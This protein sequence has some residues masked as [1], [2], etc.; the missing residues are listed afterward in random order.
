MH[1]NESWSKSIKNM[2]IHVFNI[3]HLRSTF[4]RFATSFEEEEHNGFPE[5]WDILWNVH[6]NH[7]HLASVLSHAAS[8]WPFETRNRATLI[9][10]VAR[11]SPRSVANPSVLLRLT[12]S[13]LQ[14]WISAELDI[15]ADTLNNLCNFR[16]LQLWAESCRDKL[17]MAGFD[18]CGDDRYH[19][20]FV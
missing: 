3:L 14:N 17:Q 5:G 12:A 8:I 6:R 18:R 9:L 2:F 19:P 16:S 13:W 4:A 7:A 1:K 15:F 11:E 20:I 10:E